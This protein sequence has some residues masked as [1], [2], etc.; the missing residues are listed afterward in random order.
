MAHEIGT[1]TSSRTVAVKNACCGHTI[2]RISASADGADSAR[3][4]TK[5]HAVM[6]ATECRNRDK[7]VGIRFVRLAR[8]KTTL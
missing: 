6:V 8:V 3:I 7:T 1:Q 2:A 5:Q 4:L